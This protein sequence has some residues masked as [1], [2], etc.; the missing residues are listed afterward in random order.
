MSNVG[1]IEFLGNWPYLIFLLI[2]F[3]P[4]GFVYFAC[5]SV[6]VEDEIPADKFI[7]W[8]RTKRTK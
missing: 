6:V 1:H 8:Y 5:K 7:E 4:L 3:F 2:M